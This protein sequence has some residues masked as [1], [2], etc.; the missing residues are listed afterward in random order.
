[1]NRFPF[2]R[3]RSLSVLQQSVLALTGVGLASMLLFVFSAFLSYQVAA[4]LLLMVVGLLA[5]FLDILPVLLASVSSALIWNFFFIQPTFTFHIN[6]A[7]DLLLFL[8]YFL[9]ALVHAVLTFKIRQAERKVLDRE[10]KERSLQ[11]YNT[12]LNSLS[13]ELR[14]PIA[15]IL[16]GIDHLQSVSTNESV[17]SVLTEME[18][19]AARLNRQIGNLLAMSRLEHK[20]IR[21]RYDWCDLKD[22][23]NRLLSWFSPEEQLR[24]ETLIPS[25]FPLIRTDEGLLEQILLNL[26]NN[27]LRYA[28]AQSPVQLNFAIRELSL[29]VTVRDFGQGIPAGQADRIFDKFYRLPDTPVGGTGLG[30]SIVRGF[31]EALNGSVRVDSEI[32][33][34]ACFVLNIPVETSYITEL[35]HE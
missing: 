24:I 3:L 26:L 14:T 28:P 9:I 6:T 32:H 20:M 25:P 33:P 30:L 8:M 23:K 35:H 16:S 4:F 27:A 11:L 15:G 13:H 17:G 1:M 34:G 7:A 31:A 10:E 5:L 2:R 18:K 29:Q 21:P 12:V 19:E 22:L